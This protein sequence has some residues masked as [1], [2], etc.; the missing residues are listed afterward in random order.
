MKTSTKRLGMAI[1]MTLGNGLGRGYSFRR[2][3][4][5]GQLAVGIVGCSYNKA[6]FGQRIQRVVRIMS[7]NKDAQQVQH[8]S[9]LAR[10]FIG[11]MA[12]GGA[13]IVTLVALGAHSWPH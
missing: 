11:L 12:L 6:R 10:V 2:L 4:G 1:L 5:L 7:T 9:Q 13:S 8:I 3:R